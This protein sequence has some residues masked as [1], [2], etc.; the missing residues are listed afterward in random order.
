MPFADAHWRDGLL[1]DQCG[2]AYRNETPRSRKVAAAVTTG[3][4]HDIAHSDF[5]LQRLIR[6][7]TVGRA[8]ASQS[9]R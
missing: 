3:L 9:S 8:E 7:R 2:L 6:Y 5:D 4:D 1:S